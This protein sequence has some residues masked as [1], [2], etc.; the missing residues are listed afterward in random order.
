MADYAEQVWYETIQPGYLICEKC[1][2]RIITELQHK[3]ETVKIFGI[4]IYHYSKIRNA[5][6]HRC[7]D[8]SE[9]SMH[10]LKSISKF[11]YTI[12]NRHM[13]RYR[14]ENVFVDI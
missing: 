3:I 14:N 9:K 4:Q 2:E 1:Y 6:C 8:Q 13:S 7:C 5:K 12:I 11:Y 10:L